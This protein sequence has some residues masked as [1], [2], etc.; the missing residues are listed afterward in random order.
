MN[1]KM[2]T[3]AILNLLNIKSA[4]IITFAGFLLMTMLN[5]IQV[6]QAAPGEYFENSYLLSSGNMLYLVAV[7]SAILIPKVNF[8][9][10]MHLNGR[11][12][13]FLAGTFLTYAVLAA[14][15]SI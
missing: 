1:K 11:K 6:V 3:V 4:Y 9:R 2:R 13:D 7:V 5:V 8:E 15:V 14:L 10:I 12:R